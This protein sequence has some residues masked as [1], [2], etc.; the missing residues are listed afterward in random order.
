MQHGVDVMEDV[1]FADC[2]VIASPEG[3]RQ[4]F[5]S[6]FIGLLRR[7]APR[8]DGGIGRILLPKLLQTPI[9]DVLHARAVICIP[10]E[11]SLII[12]IANIILIDLY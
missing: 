10:G 6:F 12:S 4:S 8:N 2:I 9:R 3:T 1:F 5:F 11:K 7:A